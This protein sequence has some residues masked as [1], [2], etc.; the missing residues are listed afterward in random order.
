MQNKGEE[1]GGREALPGGSRPRSSGLPWPVEDQSRGGQ[2]DTGLLPHAT[3]GGEVRYLAERAAAAPPL[4]AVRVTWAVGLDGDGRTRL[5]S[6]TG[7]T[8][9]APDDLGGQ[10]TVPLWRACGVS[11]R[12]R[13]RE[14]KDPV[15][16]EQAFRHR[17]IQN[18]SLGGLCLPLADFTPRLFGNSRKW[19]PRPCQKV[20]RRLIRWQSSARIR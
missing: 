4:I 9:A 20:I 3:G 13:V 12:I 11:C 15:R 7:R 5:R 10:K 2:G 14:I 8:A 19:F 17:G 16:R 6:G 1:V 18:E